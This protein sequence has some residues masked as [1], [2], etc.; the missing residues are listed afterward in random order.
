MERRWSACWVICVGLLAGCAHTVSGAYV[1]KGTDFVEMLQLTQSSNG[2]ILG[3]LSHTQVKPDGTLDQGTNNITGAAD[4]SSIT[5]VAHTPIPL[6]PNTNMSGTVSERGITL[7][8]PNGIEETFM[9]TTAEDYRSEVHHLSEL[10]QAL[11]QRLQA[12]AA[13]AEQAQRRIDLDNQVAALNQQLTDYVAL[14]ESL[15]NTQQIDAFHREHEQLLAKARKDLEI[16]HTYRR[17][18]YTADQ[19]SYAVNQIQFRLNSVNYSWLNMPDT[20]RAH[21]REFDAAIAHS[22]CAA[23]PGLPH[24]AAQPAAIRAYQNARSLVAKQCDDVEAT[25]KKD[26]AA[27]KALADQ[28]DQ[29]TRN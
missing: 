27:M 26:D 22:P 16:Q 12:Q 20:G 28:S 3:T 11:R 9:E 10:G 24:C 8:L 17:G 13:R 5:L 1:S 2:A 25:I 21:L 29:Y 7:N 4:G 6:T 19:G 23:Q 18:S 14:V 15:K